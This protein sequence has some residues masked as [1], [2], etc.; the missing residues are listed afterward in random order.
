M[1]FDT[2]VSYA[3]SP[4][5]DPQNTCAFPHSVPIQIRHYDPA[6]PD[7][8]VEVVEASQPLL[9]RNSPVLYLRLLHALTINR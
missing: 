4:Q 8:A 3:E 7:F 5:L 2:K 9:I 6:F 1:T